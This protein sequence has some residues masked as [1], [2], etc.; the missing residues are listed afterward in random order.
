MTPLYV[1]SFRDLATGVGG[2]VTGATVIELT[3]ALGEAFAWNSPASLRDRLRGNPKGARTLGWQEVRDLFQDKSVCFLIHGFNVNRDRGYAGLGVLAQELLGLGPKMT[4]AKPK[5]ARIAQADLVVPVIW[6]GDWYIP[7]V[8]YPFEMGDVYSTAEQFAAFLAGDGR[9]ALSVS[10]V[11]HSLGA[12]IILDTLARTLPKAAGRRM[13]IFDAA[14]MTA[15][16]AD[17]DI[18]DDPRFAAAVAALQRILIVSSMKDSVL[19]DAFPPGDK[20]EAALWRNEK[21]SAYALGAFGPKL[22]PGSPAAGK[23]RWFPIDP[24]VGQG[25]DDYLPWPWKT[26]QKPNGWTPKRADVASFLHEA[27][28]P[29][30]FAPKWPAEAKPR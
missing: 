25:H 19:R 29:G 21:P 12:R 7:G 4:P 2:A 24:A 20:V 23:V 22:K 5:G 18:L 13:P 16:A 27:F 28:T 17:E 9:G 30:P 11:S 8:N 14:I 1:L 26:N 15:P 3:G 10:F 6:P